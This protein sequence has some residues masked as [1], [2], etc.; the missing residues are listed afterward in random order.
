MAYQ[1]YNFIYDGIPSQ[2]YGLRIVSFESSSYRHVGGS[3][4]ELVTDRAARS[5]RTKILHSVPSEPLEFEMEIAC[6]NSLSMAQSLYVKN[7]LFGH[8]GYK[9]LQ[10]LREDMMDYYFN[11]I[12]NNPEDIQINGN[13]GWKFTVICDAGGAWE[14]PRT[15]H[16]NIDNTDGPTTI[17]INNCSNNHDYTYPDVSFKVSK[18]GNVSIKNMDDNGRVFSFIE[19]TADEEININGETKIITSTGASTKTNRL[20]NF[21][22][23]FLRLVPGTNKLIV[24]GIS[25]LEI[26]THNFRRIGG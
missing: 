20:G 2:A 10:I 16:Y 6:E 3:A 11:C 24:E 7:W 8:L 1:G 4:M 25:S 13:N 12:L 17:I 23:N 14:N 21:N 9:K 19:L 18:D 5:L 15:F 22:K 26:T